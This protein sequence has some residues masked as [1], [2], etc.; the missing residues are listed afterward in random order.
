[1]SGVAWGTEFRH[2]FP[3]QRHELPAGNPQVEPTPQPTAVSRVVIK[4]VQF[5]HQFFA[6]A[7]FPDAAD[8]IV[9][10]REKAPVAALQ[11]RPQDSRFPVKTPPKDR[12]FVLV[13][14]QTQLLAY[15]FGEGPSRNVPSMGYFGGGEK[16]IGAPRASVLAGRR[17]R[18]R[19]HPR[20]EVGESVR[21]KQGRCKIIGQDSIPPDE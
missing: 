10:G 20:K 12:L 14:V 4:L 3:G 8:E 19:R 18:R 17:R 1:V 9:I 11:Q 13:W 21:S 7:D 15:A 2:D 6:P 16:I 5:P